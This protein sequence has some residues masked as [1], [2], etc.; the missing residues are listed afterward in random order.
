MKL[1][2]ALFISLILLMNFSAVAGFSEL[3]RMP[4]QDGGRIKPYDTFAREVLQLVYGKQKYKGKLAA[5]VVFTWLLV[6]QH[7]E[8]AKIIQI[9]HNGIREALKL[10]HKRLF[11]SPEELMT[12]ERVGLLIQELRTKKDN[13]EKLNPYYQ[14]VQTL[15]NQISVFHAMKSGMGL[16]VV[17]PAEGTTW[18]TVN[19]LK[20]LDAEKFSAIG[21]AFVSYAAASMKK[22]ESLSKKLAEVNTAVVGFVKHVKE[23]HGEDYAPFSQVK[24]EVHY[25]DFHPFLWSWILYLVGAIFLIASVVS[26]R[27]WFYKS[28]WV[29][30][31]LGFALHTYGFGLRAFIIGRAPVTNMYETVVWVAWGA[32]VFAFILERMSRSRY[33]LISASIIATFCLILTDLSAHVLDGSLQPLEPVLRDNFW[34]VTH[35]LIITLSYAAFFLAFVIADLMLFYFLKDE[36]KYK[37]QIRQG[38]VSIYRSIQIGIVLLAA[39]IILG[40]IW[41]DYS[42]GRFWGWDPKETWAFIALMGY[43]AIL[44]AR[45]TG[46]LRDFGLA[47]TSIVGFAL[48]IMAWYGVNFVLGA[49]LHTYGFGAGGVEYVS[50]FVAIHI[51][52][53]VFAVTVRS[54]KKK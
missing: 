24:A 8:D 17:P 27:P 20:G 29:F 39:G 38:S 34:L 12:N 22:D 33:V 49:G 53:V 48:V 43:L 41:A 31:I 1:I 2:K 18:V 10:E 51:L 21:Q 6:P 30:A 19:Q 25:N 7:W 54:S 42:W 28:G 40:G 14:A 36:K 52:Y 23:R 15:E 50:A 37:K 4:V 26:P 9:R 5:E 13:K 11:Y 46:W 45:L 32:L 35:V 16:R 44:H 3:K 47:V